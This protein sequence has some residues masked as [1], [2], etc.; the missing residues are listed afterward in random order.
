MRQGFMATDHYFTPP[1][2]WAALWLLCLFPWLL[3]IPMATFGACFHGNVYRLFP[4]QYDHV[5]SM[6]F[7]ICTAGVYILLHK[8]CGPSWC[9]SVSVLLPD[10]VSIEGKSQHT[11]RILHGSVAFSVN[12]FILWLKM[13]NV[14]LVFFL[15]FFR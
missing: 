12:K 15:K 5:H 4:W 1:L 2:L 9:T 11:A 8:A 6:F 10:C 3:L 14:V 7:G 13:L